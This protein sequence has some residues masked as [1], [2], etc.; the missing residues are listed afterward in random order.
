VLLEWAEG[1]MGAG[2]DAVEAAR[3]QPVNPGNA[4]GV[5]DL[6][7]RLLQAR[8]PV[9]L[10][11]Q[12]G[13]SSAT[14]VERLAEALPAPVFTTCSG[15]GVVPEDHRFSLGFDFPRGDL[16]RLNA[17]LAESDLVVVLGAKL[18]S[19]GTSFF[20]LVLPEDRLVH[21]DASASVAGATYPASLRVVSPLQPVLERLLAAIGAAGKTGSDWTPE[22]VAKWRGELYS[23][24]GEDAPELAVRGVSPPTAAGFFAAMRRALPREA[25][26]VADSGLHQFLLRRHFEVRS[27]RGLIVPSDFQ[28]IGFALAAAIGA[29]LANPH[30]PVV[31]VVGDG[32]LAASGMEIL[33]AVR[34][35]IA[36][37]VVV[38]NDG[39]LNLIRV[40]QLAHAG[41][42]LGVELKNPDFEGFAAAMGARYACLD[43]DDPERVLR[44]AAGADAVTVVEVRVGDSVGLRTRATRARARGWLADRLGPGAMAWL[45]GRFGRPRVS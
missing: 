9:L 34:E 41:R 22:R 23:P 21:V 27:P 28:S 40:A 26:V 7:S 8:R 13:A 24:T 37:T 38:W 42:V 10:V 35:K 25:I 1:A 19:A 45:K 4:Q 5:E 2:T 6:V 20:G 36:L 39:W 33:T 14:L 11:G 32:G 18:T 17:F 44:A 29:R 31:A 3:P 12:G 43:T 16:P 30:R 15:R